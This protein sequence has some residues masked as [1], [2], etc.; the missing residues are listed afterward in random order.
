MIVKAIGAE[1]KTACPL[2][3]RV[4]VMLKS[5]MCDSLWLWVIFPWF[6]I[7]QA[8]TCGCTCSIPNKLV[9]Y[10][11]SSRCLYPDWR[12]RQASSF[13]TENGSRST[14]GQTCL[15]SSVVVELRAPGLERECIGN[16]GCRGC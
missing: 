6:S 9:D 1:E 7:L 8:P 15:G 2:L 3:L 12:K 4:S 5:Y 13:V 10:L 16:S 14:R 11:P